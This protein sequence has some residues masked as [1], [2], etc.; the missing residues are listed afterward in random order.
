MLFRAFVVAIIAAAA[1]GCATPTSE[2]VAAKWKGKNI[3]EAVQ[4]LGPPQ[5]TM[6]MPDNIT[7]YTWEEQF[8][9]A[10]AAVRG[11]CRTG[12][13]VDHKGTIVAAS[14]VS[15]SLLCK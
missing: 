8:G 2:S 7:I 11:Y 12:L 3:T 10:N 15:R 9:S 4:V 13:H 1:T 14:Q 6:P 5:S